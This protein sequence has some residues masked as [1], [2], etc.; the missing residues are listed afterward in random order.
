MVFLPRSSET[1]E[2]TPGVYLNNS[3]VSL[4][5]PKDAVDFDKVFGKP[6]TH[7]GNNLSVDFDASRFNQ[8]FGFRRDV[9]P[10]FAIR[11]CNLSII[12]PLFSY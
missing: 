8:F 9:K 1:L 6:E 2:M 12:S 10:E 5:F 3:S 7:F 11:F 4:R